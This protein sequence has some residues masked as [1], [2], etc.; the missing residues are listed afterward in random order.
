VI[1][2]AR[3]AGT[4]R[5]LNAQFAARQV[6]KVYHALVSGSPPWDEKTVALPLRA[7]VG[8]RKR[9]VV[10][11]QGGKPASTELKVLERFENCTFVEARPQTGRRHQIRAHLY[12]QGFPVLSDDLYGSGEVSPW[13]ER[14]ALHAYALHLQHPLTGEQMLFQAPYSADFSTALKRLQK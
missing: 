3:D 9:T 6:A 5:A 13:I 14:L 12:D 2:L 1:A 10:D 8:R 11:R 7:N 4:H